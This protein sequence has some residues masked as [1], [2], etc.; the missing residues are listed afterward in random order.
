[1][2]E[3]NKR[4]KWVDSLKGF[5]IILVVIGHVADGYINSGIYPNEQNILYMIFKIIYSFHMQLFFLIS[6]FLFATAYFKEKKLNKKNVM[7]Q[8]INLCVIYLVFSVFQWGVKVIFKNYVN[9][10]YDIYDL[11]KI[12]IKPMPP[13]WYLYDLIIFYFGGILLYKFNKKYVKVILGITISIIISYILK[14][15]NEIQSKLNYFLFFYL[16][17]VWK[18]INLVEK[19]NNI[20]IATILGSGMILFG[21]SMSFEKLQNIPIINICI[22]LLMSVTIILIFNKNEKIFNNKIFDICGKYCLEI[23]VLHCFF[24]ALNRT[25]LIKMG[26]TNFYINFI[27]N[28]VISTIIPILGA[29]LLKKMKLYNIIFKP[30]KTLGKRINERVESN[31]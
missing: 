31:G 6:G 13:Y 17:V 25:L 3:E 9:D 15:P 20:I 12:F 28:S 1:M 8:I 11:L 26:I 30:V 22:A 19:T 7:L 21:L 4:I 5:A 14:L 10:Q 24:T 23:Y 27:V 16:G 29:V 18:E 2:K